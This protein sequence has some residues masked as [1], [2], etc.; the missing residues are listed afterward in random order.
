L[1]GG[2]AAATIALCATNGGAAQ[3]NI[4]FQPA[5][6]P[7]PAGYLADTGLVYAD[8]NN[9]YT[10][11]WNTDTTVG[12]RDRDA[13]NSPDQRY[14]TLN[15]MQKF[16]NVT[17]EI[18]VPNGSYQVQV[19][20][21]DPS[22]I[23][24]VYKIAVEGVLTVDGTPTTSTHWIE[25]TQTVTVSDGKL[26]VS[27]AV[28]SINNKICFLE[29]T[30]FTPIG[31][32]PP[33]TPAITEPSTDGQI[34]HPADVH[35]ETSLFSDANAGQAHVCSDFEIRVASTSELA[36]VDSCDTVNLVHVHLGDGAFVNSYAGRTELQY[37]TDY[38]LRARHKDSSGDPATEWSGWGV[39]QFHTAPQPAPGTP[40]AW[41]L[42]Q[43]GFQLDV[44]ATGLTLPI[45]IAFRPTPGPQPASPVFYVTE[46]YGNIKVVSRDGTVS[47]YV[48]GVLNYRPNGIFPGSGEQGLTGIVVDPASGDL[49][50]S[51]LYEA[52]PGGP[53]Y[54]K[55]MRFF[56][57]ET[58]SVSGHSVTILDMA[59]ESQGQSHQISNLSIGRDGKLYAHNGDGFDY[60]TAQNLN[61]FRGKILRLNLDGSAPSDNPYYDAS[62]GIT[63][64]DYVYALGFR[65]PFGGDWRQ[66]DGFHYEVENG[67]SVDRFAKVVAGRNYLWDG[68]DASMMNY[69]LYNW[70]PPA[71]APVNVAFVQPGTFGGSGFPASKQ[72]HAFVSQSGPTYASGPQTKAKNITEF[73][74]DTNGNR[75]SGPT[76]LLDYTGTGKATVAGLAA[77]PDG[78]YFTDLYKDLNATSP[79]DAGANVLRIR[80]VGTNQPPTAAI[81]NPAEGASFAAPANITIDATASDADGSVAKVEFFH[82]STKIGED[83]T[84][85]YSVVWSGATAGSYALTAIATDN[86]G[87]Q[88]TSAPAYITVAGNFSVSASPG[89][90]SLRRGESASY[91]AKIT[92]TGG[93]TGNVGL[94]VGPLPSGVTATFSANPVSI[95]G[96]GSVSSTLTLSASSSASLGS[97]ALTI[98]G[99]NGSVQ[100]TASVSLNVRK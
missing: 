46:L 32:V 63:A 83:T 2:F 74:L 24:S 61:S 30:A 25:G 51:M 80:Y 23:D 56:S 78:L 19:V 6:A 58:G 29:F 48:R 4:N 50:V 38:T 8:R 45:N 76:T 68:S 69:A 90:R 96:T 54:P 73:E 60:T 66:A 85:P 88:T 94:S 47:D 79:T 97:V 21:G 98:T 67:P 65:N 12:T 93:F 44:V 18:S 13:A 52:Y 57:N 35:M 10:Y 20:A 14:D 3:V 71:V 37:D 31:N 11:G 36:W 16:G 15:H 1:L 95:A 99:S 92:P 100:H 41:T 34:V 43:V 28:G 62:D 64:K 49:F 75:V 39:R 70:P 84:A 89:A 53:H 26:T 77:G 9:G 72:G 17:W 42:R 59:G 27:N 40:V 82:D 7:V 22:N 33:A 55:I 86:Q 87:A 5:G 81:T 91:T